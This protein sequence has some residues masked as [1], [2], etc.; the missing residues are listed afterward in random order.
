MHTAIDLPIYDESQNPN[1]DLKYRQDRTYV[2]GL[3]CFSVL[4]C[5]FLCFALLYFAVLCCTLLC[6]A[7]MYC[8]VLYLVLFG[9]VGYF[10]K[11][12]NISILLLPAITDLHP[13]TLTDT[14]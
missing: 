12:T 4:F 2:K 7:V 14:P 3:V 10:G 9:F 11:L 8:N 1:T 5:A 13:P 6:C